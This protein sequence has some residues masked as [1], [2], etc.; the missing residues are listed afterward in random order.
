MTGK[1]LIVDSWVQLVVILYT[2][3]PL[4]FDLEE[5][6]RDAGISGAMHVD[7]LYR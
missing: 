5:K 1:R 2:T 4:G 3:V 6:A 7:L